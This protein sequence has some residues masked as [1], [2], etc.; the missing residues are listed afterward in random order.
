[1]EANVKPSGGKKGRVLG[2]ILARGG[3]KRIPRKNIVDF[4]GRPM[5]SYPLEAARE[6]GLFD[7]IHVSSDDLEI[8]RIATEWGADSDPERPSHLADDHTP[9]LPVAQWVLRELQSGGQ[10]FDDVV[11][12]FP[13]SPFLD[14]DDLVAAY[15][16][17]LSHGRQRNLLTV[18]K[19]PAKVEYYYR[20]DGSGA[21]APIQP[22]G[23]FIR[24]QDLDDAYFETG[25]FTIFSA[26][27]LLTAESLEDDN[28]YLGYE[29]APA[30]SVDIDTPEDLENAKILFKTGRARVRTET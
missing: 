8:R 10:V 22:G 28:R 17:Y 7:R 16:L 4:F 11:I 29:L 2:L 13:C 23:S 14:A 24:S 5:L 9:M 19:V 18:C 1:M 27:W 6:S 20:M 30:K 3:S 21:L 25:T 26:D 12:L 15:D